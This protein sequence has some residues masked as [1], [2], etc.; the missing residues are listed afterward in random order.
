MS[1][2]EITPLNTYERI[3]DHTLKHEGIRDHT[4]KEYERSRDHALKHV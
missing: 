1:V 2:V 4:F 3:R